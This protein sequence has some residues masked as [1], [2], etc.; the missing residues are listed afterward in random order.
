[1]KLT[2]KSSMHPALVSTAILV[3][4]GTNETKLLDAMW[5]LMYS[6]KGAGLAANQVGILKRVIVVHAKGFKQEF[7]N[8]VITKRYGGKTMSREG[9]LSYPG[10]EMRISRYKNIVVEG[11][12]GNWNPIK[13]KLKG[14]AAYCVQHEIDHLN[15][16]TIVTACLPQL[17]D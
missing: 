13:R 16:K 6:S 12:D 8:P 17:E 9:C 11:F 3:E 10:L 4:H 7:I 1:M 5:A 15:G 2:L 14:L